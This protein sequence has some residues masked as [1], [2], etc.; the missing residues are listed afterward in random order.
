MSNKGLL[1]LEI[2]IAIDGYSGTGKSSTAKA[3]SKHFGYKYLDSGAMYRS[4]ALS[5]IQRNIDISDENEVTALA[6]KIEIGFNKLGNVFINGNEV[7][8]E[9]RS[10][11]VNNAVSVVSQY[12]GVRAAMVQ[13]QRQLSKDEG[14][15][16]DGRDIGTVVFPDAELKVF[17][18]ASPE[19]RADRRQKELHQKG[20]DENLS[21]ILKNLVERDEMDSNRV[22]SPLKKANGV[23][24]IDTSDLKFADQVSEIVLLAEKIINEG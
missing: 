8:Q 13:Q 6:E 11:E 24:V 18:T 12:K 2:I 16:M 10:M 9:I 4:V 7:T 17:M 5:C 20:V 15:V 14:V 3:V 23:I 1:M 19:V 21:D 22:E